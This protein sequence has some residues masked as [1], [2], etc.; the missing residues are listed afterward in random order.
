M[1]SDNEPER[2]ILCKSSEEYINS[3]W[4]N[5]QLHWALDAPDFIQPDKNSPFIFELLSAQEI[6]VINNIGINI[7][8][9]HTDISYLRTKP[10]PMAVPM[11][12]PMTWGPNIQKTFTQSK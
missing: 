8:V 1:L 12:R 3:S 10:I 4:S 9:L 7:S 5:M 2:L 6:R 11:T